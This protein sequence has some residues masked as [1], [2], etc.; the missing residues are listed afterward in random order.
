MEVLGFNYWVLAQTL[1]R[2][3]ESM[4]Y[5]YALPFQ[6][7]PILKS[8]AYVTR[9]VS[10]E[11][12][13][14]CLK[15]HCRLGQG[16]SREGRQ[17][18]LSKTAR[19]VLVL[20]GGAKQHVRKENRNFCPLGAGSSCSCYCGRHWVGRCWKRLQWQAGKV[21]SENEPRNHTKLNPC[22]RAI[23]SEAFDVNNCLVCDMHCGQPRA[24]EKN[25]HS[26]PR[27]SVSG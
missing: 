2:W 15:L 6:K 27:K 16:K 13:W 18:H 4:W 1:P 26:A 8:E 11:E 21:V 5:R 19:A 14:G 20:E 12:L 17:C 9:R 7:P 23:C 24:T 10:Y 25:L 22:L 3:L